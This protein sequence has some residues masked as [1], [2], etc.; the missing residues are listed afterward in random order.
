VHPNPVQEQLTLTLPAGA[1]P[2]TMHIHDAVGRTVL[3]QQLT[4][5]TARLDLQALPAGS[6]RCVLTTAQ[7]RMVKGFVKE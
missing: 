7:G 5:T 4:G 2:V 3:Q 1:G 6:Y